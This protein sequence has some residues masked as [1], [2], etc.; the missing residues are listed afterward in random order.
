MEEKLRK[1]YIWEYDVHRLCHISE[2]LGDDFFYG[3]EK[4]GFICKTDRFSLIIA[5]Y[6]YT[7]INCLWTIIHSFV[8]GVRYCFVL[9]VKKPP[10]NQR[11]VCACFALMYEKIPSCYCQ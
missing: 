1:K 9:N 3:C 7:K 11:R 4:L 6:K 2:V 10:Y 5:V 8:K